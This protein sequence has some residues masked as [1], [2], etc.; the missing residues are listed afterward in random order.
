MV[1]LSEKPRLIQKMMEREFMEDRRK[2][3]EDRRKLQTFVADDRRSGIADRRKMPDRQTLTSLTA[4][5]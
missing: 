2:A 1:T 3:T 5:D 4:S